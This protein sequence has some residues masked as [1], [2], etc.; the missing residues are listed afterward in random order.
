VFPIESSY[1]A[2]IL[3]SE[4][5][6]FSSHHIRSRPIFEKIE[7]S[8]RTKKVVESVTNSAENLERMGKKKKLKK[9]GEQRRIKKMLNPSSPAPNNNSRVCN[10]QKKKST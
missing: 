4:P 6:G 9:P 7:I 10:Q 1:T 3:E 2:V 5:R 8:N